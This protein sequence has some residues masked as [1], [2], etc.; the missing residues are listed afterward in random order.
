MTDK[1]L[2]HRYPD[3]PTLVADLEDALA[4]E[5]ARAGHARP[6]RRPPSCARSPRAPRRRLPFRL[7]RPRPDPRRDR[8]CSL[9]VG[10]VVAVAAAREGVERTQRGTGA[11]HGQAARR[12]RRSSRSSARQR[13]GLRPA[14]RRRRALRPG[15]RSPSTA[16]PARPGRPRATSGGI[17]GA[18]KAGVGI[19]VDAKPGVDAV[20]DA[21]SRHAEARLEGRDLRRA[22]RRPR[23]ASTG[24]RGLDEGRR[25]HRHAASTSASSSTPAAS[26]TATTSSGSRSCRPDQERVEISEIAPV[27]AKT[28]SARTRG[29]A[30]SA[31]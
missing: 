4:L 29:R 3:A 12:A 19:Y 2:A 31:R 28:P 20:R 18:G 22:R 14:R 7:R 23:A 26:A 5:A 30:R 25:R 11:G 16:T 9:L 13:P 6:A 27:R 21:R 1:D 8:R 10:A 24:A 15:A 17:A